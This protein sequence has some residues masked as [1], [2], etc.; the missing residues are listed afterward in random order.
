MSNPAEEYALALTRDQVTPRQKDVVKAI[1]RYW[2]LRHRSANISLE[3][4]CEDLLMDRR[5]LRRMLKKLDWCIEYLPGGGQHNHSHFRL[6]AVD[7]EKV[8]EIDHERGSNGGSTGVILPTA[9]RKDLNL[10]QNQNPPDPPFSKGGTADAVPTK[11]LVTVR[12]VRELREQITLAQRHGLPLLA[13]IEEA[14]KRML[15]P[16]NAAVE[17]FAASGHE[18]RSEELRTLIEEDPCRRPPRKAT[19]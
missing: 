11:K 1:A 10:S 12:Q 19:A 9:I 15:F 4:L 2:T 17:L 5:N 14:C 18:E 6:R 16:L 3:T 13:A 7:V 8:T